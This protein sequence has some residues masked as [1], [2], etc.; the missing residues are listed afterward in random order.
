MST[1]RVP[2]AIHKKK[3]AKV[4]KKSG[5]NVSRKA[6][7]ELSPCTVFC[8]NWTF[9]DTSFW[10]ISL[11]FCAPYRLLNHCHYWSDRKRCIQAVTLLPSWAQ[12]VFPSLGA[13]GASIKLSG[14]QQ[15]PIHPLYP[16][17]NKVWQDLG[18]SQTWTTSTFDILFQLVFWGRG[19]CYTKSTFWSV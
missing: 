8:L 18:D 15:T 9:A 1:S 11:I 7:L 17:Q 6:F 4:N 3:V 19:W 14:S 12:T 5:G 2:T 10:C 16:P 13:F